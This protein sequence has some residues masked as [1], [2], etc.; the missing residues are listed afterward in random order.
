M[1]QLRQKP[2]ICK[3]S[4]L[5]VLYCMERSEEGSKYEKNYVFLLEETEIQLSKLTNLERLESNGISAS[6]MHSLLSTSSQH[7]FFAYPFPTAIS[8]CS[9]NVS[10]LFHPITYR[11]FSFVRKSEFES[12]AKFKYFS[13]RKKILV[14]VKC[15]FK[16]K[17]TT[18]KTN[19]MFTDTSYPGNKALVANKVQTLV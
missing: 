8:L 14:M 18:A 16:E 12:K 9:S 11:V 6:S 4:N 15:A 19:S 13:A 10:L 7:S 2:L 17:A 5:F 1:W 3:A